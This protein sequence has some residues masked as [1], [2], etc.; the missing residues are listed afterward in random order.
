MRAPDGH[1][2]LIDFGIARHFKPDQT[3]DTAYYAS[4]G[5]APPEQYGEAQTTPR[6][7]IYSLG[8]VLHQMLSGH[9]PSMTP[10]QMPSLLTQFP[11]LPPR[12][13]QC[14]AQM[15][16]LDEQR[17]PANVLTVRQIL[18]DHVTVPTQLPP[19]PPSPW[20]ILPTV[21]TGS[22]QVYTPGYQPPVVAGWPP[23]SAPVLSSRG[24][25]KTVVWVLLLVCIVAVSGSILYAFFSHNGL[26][27]PLQHVSYPHL[28]SSYG[29]TTYDMTYKKSG[30]LSLSFSQ[31]Q[32]AISGTAQVFA[33]GLMDSGNFTGT[34][35]TDETLQS[36]VTF[37][38]GGVCKMVG[39]ISSQ[40]TL[41]GTYTTTYPNGIFPNHQ[42][43]WEASPN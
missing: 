31:N 7:D 9:N 21:P 20:L 2:Y 43:T 15:L 12:L 36:T 42:G 29:G 35:G 5:Y 32:Q 22:P 18:A 37:S 19:P 34:V 8:V 33:N 13:A 28:S 17:R 40:K 4:T 25:R 6:S 41:S 11:P 3:K 23:T 14:I 38:S 24:P 10:F 26:S 30:N 1:I 16:E 39:T 27:N